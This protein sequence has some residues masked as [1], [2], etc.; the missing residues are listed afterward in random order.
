MAEL[1]NQ[2]QKEYQT[3]LEEAHCKIAEINEVS[4]EAQKDLFV[5][6]LPENTNLSP[7]SV[8]NNITYVSVYANKH[9][10]K[11]DFWSYRNYKEFNIARVKMSG[12]KLFKLMHGKEH[13]QFEKAGKLYSDFLKEQYKEI[14]PVARQTTKQ[15]QEEDHKEKITTE[16]PVITPA[17]NNS[18]IRKC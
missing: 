10:G 7:I 6:W 4:D 2:N 17:Q 13:R 18:I 5:K 3:I 15:R 9:G 1:Y 11:K 12:S 16:T 14:E 8:I